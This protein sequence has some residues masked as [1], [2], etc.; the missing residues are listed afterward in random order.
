MQDYLSSHYYYLL[1]KKVPIFNQKVAAKK[2]IS[3][4]Q[5]IYEVKTKLQGGKKW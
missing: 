3:E 2:N 5:E 4:T 1:M